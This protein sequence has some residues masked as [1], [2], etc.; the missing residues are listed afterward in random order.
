MEQ[1]VR[2]HQSRVVGVLSGWDRMRFRGTLRVLAAVPGLFT[3]LNEQGV[4]L[5]NFQA[6]AQEQT[7]RLKASVEQV[8]AAAKRTIRRP[9]AASPPRLVAGSGCF[10]IKGCS[11][12]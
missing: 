7:E 11:T 9:N 2:E 1:F 3:W 10:A 6:F 4:L 8:A 12:A 5:Q